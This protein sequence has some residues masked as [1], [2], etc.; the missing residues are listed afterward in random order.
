M[1]GVQVPPEEPSLAPSCLES[2]HSP[3]DLRA[4]ARESLS[5]KQRWSELRAPYIFHD[6]RLT[7]APL[8][9]AKGL[10]AALA[11]PAVAL[12]WLEFFGRLIKM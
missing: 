11:V 7:N 9:V 1:L 4:V 2:D 10:A 8:Q 5:A 3:L 12:D 6:F